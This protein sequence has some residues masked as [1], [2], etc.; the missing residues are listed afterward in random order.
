LDEPVLMELF[1]IFFKSLFF[2]F[3]IKTFPTLLSTGSVDGNILACS[4]SNQLIKL[5]DIQ[6]YTYFELDLQLNLLCVY[7]SLL[8]FFHSSRF[9]TQLKGHT[10]TIS[11]IIFSTSN[12]HFLYS[13]SHD[14]Y[15]ALWDTRQSSAAL[16]FV[17]QF[18]GKFL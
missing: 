9:I 1:K 2:A 18:N 8:F 6:T 11:D 15:A 13:C 10:D 12:P 14:G 17:P 4:S 3:L 5:Y 16:Q 7:L